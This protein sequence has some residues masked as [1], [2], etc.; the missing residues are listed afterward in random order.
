MSIYLTSGVRALPC[1]GFPQWDGTLRV[2]AAAAAAAA[3][4][5]RLRRVPKV[6]VVNQAVCT[7]RFAALAI[8]RCDFNPTNPTIVPCYIAR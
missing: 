7:P 2:T 1:V 5:D 3:A 8:A 4:A 6:F